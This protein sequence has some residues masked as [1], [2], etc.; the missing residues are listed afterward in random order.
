VRA[1]RL[2]ADSKI[3]LALF[4]EAQCAGG[5]LNVPEICVL[6]NPRASRAR[7]EEVDRIGSHEWEPSVR[8]KEVRAFAHVSGLI[9]GVD[10]AAHLGVLSSA[11]A[12]VKI[13]PS[14]VRHI[15]GTAGG[16]NLEKVDGA[17][18]GGELVAHG[19]AAWLH[20]PIRNT[21]RVDLAA[22][23]ADRRR[24]LVVWS[25]GDASASHGNGGQGKSGSNL[26]KHLDEDDFK[27]Q[28]IE[29]E[30]LCERYERS[31]SYLMY[32]IFGTLFW[33][34]DV[35]GERTGFVE[36]TMDKRL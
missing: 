28:G 9:L 22:E 25:D 13:V 1:A 4:V 7:N 23:D 34:T 14:V 33:I 35:G 30:V 29:N 11:L 16:V 31:S 26:R 15:I 18:V 10:A 24:I 32:M 5:V 21:I 2:I 20:G 36:E 6:G 12:S 8:G 3:E 19:V 27:L 17:A